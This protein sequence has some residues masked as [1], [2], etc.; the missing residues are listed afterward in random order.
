M[1]LCQTALAGSKRL[2][3]VYGENIR[4]IVPIDS[5]I[6]GRA[7]LVTVGAMM[8]GSIIQTVKEGQ[9]V[10]RG[11]ECELVLVPRSSQIY[12]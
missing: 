3:Q 12:G 10:K 9:Q 7:M 11:E 8:V 4:E 1:W 5:P 2:N 6:F